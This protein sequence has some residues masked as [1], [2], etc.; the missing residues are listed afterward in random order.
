VA[1]WRPAG[2]AI[3]VVLVDEPTGWVAFFCT[4][5][6]APVAEIL[7]AVAAR[8]RQD[9]GQPHYTPSPRWCGPRTTGYQR[10][11]GAV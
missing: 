5:V 7:G 6:S 11:R 8:F 1:T 3:R 10:R 4:A 2:G 9:K